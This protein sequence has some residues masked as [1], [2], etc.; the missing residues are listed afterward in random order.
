VEKRHFWGFLF[1]KIEIGY[2]N[3]QTVNGKEVKLLKVIID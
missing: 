1:F 3:S 2:F